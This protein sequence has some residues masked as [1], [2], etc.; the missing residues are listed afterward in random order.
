VAK[1]VWSVVS[2]KGGVGKTTFVANWGAHLAAAGQ[3]TW[4]LDADLG[5]GDLDVVLGATLPGVLHEAWQPG[6][7]TEF[8]E[9]ISANLFATGNQAGTGFQFMDD[10]DMAAA[11]L[12]AKLEASDSANIILDT[13]SGLTPWTQPLLSVATDV[14]MVVGA[15]PSSV[16]GAFAFVSTLHKLGWQPQLHLVV[17]RAPDEQA[18]KNVYRRLQQALSGNLNMRI[19]FAGWLPEDNAVGTHARRRELVVTQSPRSRYARQLAKISDALL[20][21]DAADSPA[22]LAQAA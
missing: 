14:L 18:A 4:L 7:N 9:A 2:G 5:I 19:E 15:D 1:R 12:K 20:A 16:S 21:S 6:G 11:S 13:T 17:N 10:W 3:S 8:R 22:P